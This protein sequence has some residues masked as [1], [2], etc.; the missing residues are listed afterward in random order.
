MSSNYFDL[1]G[2]P[3][4]RSLG[5]I[6]LGV[7]LITTLILYLG[8]SFVITTFLVPLAKPYI[9]LPQAVSEPK[10][11]YELRCTFVDD[12]KTFIH[13][14]FHTQMDVCRIMKQCF[15]GSDSYG[16]QEACMR[17]LPPTIKYYDSGFWVEMVEGKEDRVIG[18]LSIHHDVVHNTKRGGDDYH[19]LIIYNVCVDQERRGQG[20]GRKMVA[21][22]VDA[23]VEHYGLQKYAQATGKEIDPQTGLPIPPLVVA[24]DVDLTSETMPEAFSLYVKLGYVRWWTPCSSVA[25]HKWSQL[26]DTQL[27]YYGKQQ[28]TASQGRVDEHGNVKR[29][30]GLL[31]TK[32][33]EFP[34]ARLLWDPQ[35][36]TSSAFNLGS[37]KRPHHFCMYKFYSDNLATI[38][39][40]LME[41][42][43]PADK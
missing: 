6:L 8:R 14:K 19:A 27:A 28:A 39:K 4:K 36:Y 35:S 22:M 37:G 3:R 5:I 33:A 11:R 23:M 12:K 10:P 17:S 25:N 40:A 32:N 18:F 31:P 29:V 9:S 43:G 13:Q 20:A 7:V 41:Q 1:N 30:S 15:I 24:L 38:A 26:I 42:S 2:T 16:T 34:F 21:G